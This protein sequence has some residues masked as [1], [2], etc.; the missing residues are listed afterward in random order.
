MVMLLLPVV[1]ADVEVVVTMAAP[2]AGG[3][4]ASFLPLSGPA[5][6]FKKE[7]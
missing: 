7:A 4:T 5:M 1:V 6:L 2:A 3:T